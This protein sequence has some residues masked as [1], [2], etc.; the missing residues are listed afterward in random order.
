VEGKEV[1]GGAVD[2]AVTDGFTG[3]VILKTSEAVAKLLVDK[4]REAIRGGGI[5]SKIGGALVRPALGSVRKVLD[6][7]EEGAAP[8]LGVNG[9]VFIGHGR[10]D[11]YAIKNA[12]RVAGLAAEAR[13]LEHIRTS[14]AERIHNAEMAPA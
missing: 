14:V 12:V 8:L 2:V 3:N 9:L 10:S 13:L 5:R 6:P 11:A 4:I 1:I 7:S